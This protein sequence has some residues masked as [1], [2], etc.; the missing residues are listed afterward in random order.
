MIKHR[1]WRSSGQALLTV[2]FIAVIGVLITTGALYALLNNINTAT[3]KEVGTMTHSAAESGIENALIR[4]IRN[5]SYTGE[6]MIF[7]DNRTVVVTVTGTSS[8]TITATATMGFVTQR[9]SV[10]I[11]YNEGVLMIDSWKSIP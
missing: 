4:L 11:H 2:I 7:D 10:V 9:V 5:P 1:N 8:Q 3:L 6:T